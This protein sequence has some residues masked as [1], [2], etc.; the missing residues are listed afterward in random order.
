MRH[1]SKVIIA[2][3]SLVVLMLVGFTQINTASST[4]GSE[5][6]NL[7]PSIDRPHATDH[8]LVKLAGVR[9]ASPLPKGYEH[10]FG[11]W[12]RAPVQSHETVQGTIERLSILPQTKVVQPDYHL[13]IGPWR[14]QPKGANPGESYLKS[15][16]F[17]PNDPLYFQQWHFPP[18][19]APTA[20]ESTQGSGVTVAII[21]SGVSK[22][23]DLACRTFVHEYNA[24]TEQSG[25][26]AADDDNGHGTHVAG[27]V[28][29]CTNNGLGV[30]GLAFA[31]NLMPVKVLDSRGTGYTSDIAR[32]IDWARTHDAAVIN[33]SLAG[34]CNGQTWPSCSIAII[35]D[36]I[37]L[38]ADEDIFITA[39]A[40]NWDDSTVGTPANHPD[41]VAVAAI[42]YHLN[43]APYSNRGEALSVSAPGGDMEQD[44][45]NDGNGDGV[46]QQSRY[47]GV[48][49]YWYSDGTSM[50][51]PHV[52]GAAAMLRELFPQATRLDLQSALETTA[53]DRG[54]PGFDTDY[55]YGIIQIADAVDALAQ[56]YDTPTP[57][58]VYADTHTDT[59][60]L[61]DVYTDTG[62]ATRNLA[63][64]MVAKLPAPYTHTDR[65]A[66]PN[67]DQY[68]HTFTDSYPNDL[69]G[70]GA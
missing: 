38:A 41:A 29:Q 13:S 61:T 19:Q 5:D 49:D 7:Q 21:D 69:R 30:T 10:I 17:V 43:H 6:T 47:N 57:T 15:M 31:A 42:D 48:W 44:E 59:H 40:G 28:A 55:G 22:G 4:T 45:N 20:W 16:T 53:L 34:R 2:A 3:L 65:D 68:P 9:K 52:A 11:D 58:L 56:Q 37:T 1:H 25:P 51:S 62:P 36:A 33:L 23:T 18:I 70:I 12:Y 60:T 67:T 63:A 46:L 32:G 39:A 27:T 50:A 14:V 54:A 35:N 24:I 26:G 66:D 8:V 64:A